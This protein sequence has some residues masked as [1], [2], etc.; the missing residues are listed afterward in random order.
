MSGSRTTIYVAP[1]DEG[2]DVW[3]PVAAE[4]LGNDLYRLLDETPEDEVWEFVTILAVL[5]IGGGVLVTRIGLFKVLAEA[6]ADLWKRP[7]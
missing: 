2:V 7:H 4:Y 6:F 3:R 5:V 1:L